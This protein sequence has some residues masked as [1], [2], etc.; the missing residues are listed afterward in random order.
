M[1]VRIAAPWGLILLGVLTAL[2]SGTAA[3]GQ[4]RDA[5]VKTEEDKSVWGEPVLGQALSIST[6][7]REYAPG[8]AIVLV[9]RIKKVGTNESP[10][11]TYDVRR[12][13]AVTMLLPDGKQPPLTAEEERRRKEPA[14]DGA[15]G[16]RLKP[17]EER[18]RELEL[19][20]IFDMTAPATYTVSVRRHV[21]VGNGEDY[22][23]VQGEVTSNRIAINVVNPPAPGESKKTAN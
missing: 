22:A 7:K 20:R 3:M 13:D 15:F 2:A 17:G 12:Q 10:S 21:V 18:R 14:R 11:F 4:N 1:A 5:V 19:T 9:I 16:V 8:E 6:E 23:R